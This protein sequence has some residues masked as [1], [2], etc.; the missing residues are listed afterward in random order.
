MTNNINKNINLIIDDSSNFKN[1]QNKNTI[2][3]FKTD[4]TLNNNNN[5]YL[6][7]EIEANKIVDAKKEF[8]ENSIANYRILKK[9]YINFS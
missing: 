1:D 9:Q 4:D 3:N 2:L 6:I 7:T 5:D 8:I